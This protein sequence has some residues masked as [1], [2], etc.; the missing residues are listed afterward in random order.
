MP[1]DGVE[2]ILQLLKII[3][4]KIRCMGEE[5]HLPYLAE[6]AIL[7]SNHQ[8]YFAVSAQIPHCAKLGE[9]N[10]IFINNLLCE[11]RHSTNVIPI[12]S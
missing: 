6:L 8:I 4:A 5:Q 2:K 3:I 11:L 12:L 1:D 9:C 7:I 10:F